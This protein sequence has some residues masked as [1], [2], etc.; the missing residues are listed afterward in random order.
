MKKPTINT[1]KIDDHEDR[2]ILAIEAAFQEKAFDKVLAA[3]ISNDWI[4]L[5]LFTTWGASINSRFKVDA[6]DAV[7]NTAILHCNILK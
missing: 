7:K 2:Y 5:K 6:V 4:E 1:L 3:H